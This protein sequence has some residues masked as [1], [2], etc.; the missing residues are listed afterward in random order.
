MIDKLITEISIDLYG[1]TKFY[2]VSAK[3]G[4]K[5]SRQIHVTL[6]NNGV[7]YE[8]P[9]NAR[10]IV[11]V[12][13]PDGH[14]CFNECTKSGN[15]IVIDMTNQMLAAAG[16]AFAD[17][18]VETADRSQILSSASFTI[19]IEQSMRNENAIM[20]SNEMTLIEKWLQDVIDS[21]ALRK[22]A[23]DERKKSEDFRKKKEAERQAAEE[24][25]IAA[26]N[27]RQNDFA[28]AIQNSEVATSEA[29]KA[30]QSA[31]NV[32][33]RAEE[34]L[35]DQALLE[36]T[37]NQVIDMKQQVSQNKDIVLQAKDEVMQESEK[38]KDT[39]EN[40]SVEA[41]K[42]VLDEVNKVADEIRNQYGTL[43]ISADGG[44]PSSVDYITIDGGSP[45]SVDSIKLDA[46]NPFSL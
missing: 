40:A 39:I 27:R 12:K 5:A 37:V 24:E 6:L 44:T 29:K 15:K 9:E 20:S 34:A 45:T 35:H 14:F 22:I 11:N 1:E 38:I 17:V 28:H 42:E 43:Y 33:E 8:I 36:Q 4:D 19:E 25:R 31:L 7:I 41:S 46:G 30:T 21:E 13:K 23:E 18:N 16:T 32:T 3:Q 26:E 10:L 2:Q